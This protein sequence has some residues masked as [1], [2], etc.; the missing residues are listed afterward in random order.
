MSPAS[1]SRVA[2]SCAPELGE[3]G[4]HRGPRRLGRRE[5]D[6]RLRHRSVDRV[7]HRRQLRGDARRDLALRAPDD[8]APR[9][10]RRRLAL[11]LALPLELHDARLAGADP[12]AER[13]DIEPRAHLAVARGLERREHPLARRRVE[14]RP[15]RLERAC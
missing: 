4:G 15:R 7:E 6:A 2:V 1:R 3:L 11:A 8:R 5:L 13:L 12:L 9:R 10:L 14:D